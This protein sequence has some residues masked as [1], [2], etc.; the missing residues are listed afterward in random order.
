MT[1]RFFAIL[2]AAAAAFKP[3]NRFYDDTHKK[4]LSNSD[5]RASVC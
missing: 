4:R 2:A 3:T 5:I 1:I